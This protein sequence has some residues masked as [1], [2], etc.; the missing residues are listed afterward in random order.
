MKD[1]YDIAIEYLTEHPKEILD[2]WSNPMGSSGGCL[3]QFCTPTGALDCK[4]I[5]GESHQ[6]GCLTQLKRFSDRIA[7]TPEL[8]NEIRADT[9]IPG[10]AEGITVADLPVFA[11]W[12]RRLDREIRN[13]VEVEV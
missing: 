10:M 5:E 4:I 12:Q 1:K 8:T 3:F 11:E 6:C 7:W 2:T 13:V 9:R